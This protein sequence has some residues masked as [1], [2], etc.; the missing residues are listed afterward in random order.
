MSKTN[1]EIELKAIAGKNGI[2][3]DG[4]WIETKDQDPDGDVRLIQMMDIGD[5]K[6]LN[7]SARFLT[8]Q[9]AK[10]LRCTFLKA[11]DVLISRMPD[12]LGRACIFPGDEH[13][14][15]TA[16]DVCIARPDPSLI[17][18]RWLKYQINWPGFRFRIEQWTTGTT[19]ARISRGNLGRIVFPLPKLE[20]QKRI[21]AILDKAD[22]IRRKRQ[23]AIEG[24]LD[25]REAIFLDRFGDPET[26][27]KKWD[28]FRIGDVAKLQGG[29]AFKSSDYV[30][31]G[32]RL[33]KISNVHHEFLEWDE[34]DSLPHGYRD[35]YSEFSLQVG[36]V[37]LALT[38]PIIKSLDSVK[39]ARVSEQDIPCL[40]NQRVGRFLIKNNDQIL[41]SYL[42]HFLYS[43]SF[44]RSVEKICSVSL[45]PNMSTR[46]VEDIR[47]PLPPVALQQEFERALH[48]IESCQSWYRTASDESDQLFNSLVQR[49]FKG[50]L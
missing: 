28:T 11:G 10:E 35:R 13:P 3:V 32:V 42:L 24:L 25:L 27:P 36:D 43:A 40:L 2:F 6:Y 22:A 18:N 41:G 20:E 47:V 19:R 15:V 23:E 5:G 21:A 31:D 48:K 17:D 44:K 12:P 26:N 8:S 1:G 39:V 7:K 37:V 49:A 34:V 46:Q 9:R 16:V 33:V 45:Q 29:Y 50:E 14:C 4:D 30:A 38:R